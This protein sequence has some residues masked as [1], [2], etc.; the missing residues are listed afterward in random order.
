MLDSAWFKE[1]VVYCG[2]Q[3]QFEFRGPAITQIARFLQWYF[4]FFFPICK[5]LFYSFVVCSGSGFSGA[6]FFFSSVF[7][8]IWKP[9]DKVGCERKQ[10]DENCKRSNGS[11]TTGKTWFLRNPC[12]LCFSFSPAGLFW[13]FCRP[14]TLQTF[15]CLQPSLPTVILLFLYPQTLLH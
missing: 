8:F 12:S 11:S 6:N 15:P 4:L 13:F 5:N 7:L 9:M 10:A 3:L 1:E 14:T 2:E